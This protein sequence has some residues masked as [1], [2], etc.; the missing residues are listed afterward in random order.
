MPEQDFG[1]PVGHVASAAGE[2]WADHGGD[3]RPL[4]V[5]SP[6]Y[7][8]DVLVTETGARL[9]VRFADDTLL[10]QGGDGRLSVDDYV[11]HQGDPSASELLFKMTQG[12]FRM[13][14]GHIADHNPDGVKMESPL[15]VIGIRGTTTL[16]DVDPVR[17][18]QPGHESHGVEELTGGQSLVITDMFG[19]V[20]VLSV[21]KL[22]DFEPGLPMFP[23]RDLTPQDIDFF[24]R[25][26]PLV[27]QG[28][29]PPDEPPPDQEP[30]SDNA[31]AEDQA[32]ATDDV[33]TDD[34]GGEP[35]GE[36]AG[37]A[38]GEELPGEGHDLLGHDL[39]GIEGLPDPFGEL[40]Y[41][42][43]LFGGTFGP[44]AWDLEDQLAYGLAEEP[45]AE[46]TAP[47]DDDDTLPGATS[48][49]TASSNWD[50]DGSTFDTTGYIVNDGDS[51]NNTLTGTASNDVLRGL[52]RR[53][54]PVGKLHGQ[55]RAVRRRGQRHHLGQRRRL[56]HLGRHGR[57]RD[58]GAQRQRHAG[59]RLGQRLLP[60]VPAH[61]DPG[62]PGRDPGLH[63]GRGQ[64]LFRQRPVH[65]GQLRGGQRLQRRGHVGP[66]LHLERHHPYLVVFGYGASGDSVAEFTNDVT[67][68]T[69][70]ITV[71]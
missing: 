8:E 65:Q 15:G 33:L 28:E 53:R 14:T 64:P 37:Q 10:A 7:A 19:N 22:V 43:A 16:H 69:T 56:Q 47:D 31:P 11:Y 13:V 67:L 5:D 46:D 60:L 3:V 35:G 54:R 62:Q 48:G 66:D 68:D 2:V 71:A 50:D 63:Q 59:G 24:H 29:A 32:A 38:Q 55:R 45:A 12:T 27:S 44:D 17:G 1:Q 51:G 23:A 52:R 6:I 9:E 4:A 57:R 41:G 25:S 61:R 40:G 34:A 36:D 58:R 18:G 26:A 20:Q 49:G 39:F 70:D 30:Q 21:P 42:T